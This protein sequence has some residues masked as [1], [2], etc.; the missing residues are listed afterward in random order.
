MNPKIKAKWVAALRSNEYKQGTRQLRTAG[1]SFC[2]LGVLCN[3]HAQAH[4]E[5]AARQARPGAYMGRSGIAPVA[6]RDWAGLLNCAGDS[7]HIN[8]VLKELAS[9]NDNG[10]T[11]AQIAY[12]IEAQL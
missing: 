1:N 10:A 9:H 7:V 6:V 3:L 4:P 11:F 5:I 12:A 8:G 2:C